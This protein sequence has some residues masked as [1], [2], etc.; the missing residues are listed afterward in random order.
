MQLD[1]YSRCRLPVV[2]DLNQLRVEL[3]H[4]TY[5]MD[6]LIAHTVDKLKPYFLNAVVIFTDT[7]Y[8]TAWLSRN[9]ND[10]DLPIRIKV[11][12]INPYFV[13]V[14]FP[15]TKPIVC[16]KYPRALELLEGEGMVILYPEEIVDKNMNLENVENK[17]FFVD[18]K[19]S[20]KLIIPA[21]WVYTV[22][23]TGNSPLVFM[24]IH[25]KD[26]PKNILERKKK[27]P[28]FIILVRSEDKEV[29]KNPKYRYIK[30]YVQVDPVS[31]VRQFNIAPKISLLSQLLKSTTKFDWL[32]TPN[33]G[34]IFKEFED[35]LIK[36]QIIEA[37]NEG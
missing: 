35:L 33:G 31:V 11:S 22:V 16:K 37:E 7:V 4:W 5:K 12:V 24:E 9:A 3:T 36:A 2:I 19:A 21:G 8:L 28:P 30:N 13:G 14:E 15:R 6:G 26:Q 20:Q 18:L 34:D 1:L 29:V 32:F 17:V 25:F 10:D 23:N 27:T